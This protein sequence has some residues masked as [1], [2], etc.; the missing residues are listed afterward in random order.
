LNFSL[1]LN[2]IIR[3]QFWRYSLWCE[4]LFQQFFK[5]HWLWNRNFIN[6]LYSILWLWCRFQINFFSRLIILNNYQFSF[7]HSNRVTYINLFIRFFLCFIL[8]WIALSFIFIIMLLKIFCFLF[9]KRVDHYLLLWR[10]LFLH[11]IVSFLF[12]WAKY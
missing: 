12:L 9:F 5:S 3:N 8:K 1:L 7:L 10:N 6:I 4:F 2:L 11:I